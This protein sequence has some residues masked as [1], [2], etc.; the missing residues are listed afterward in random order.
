[1][2][3]VQLRRPKKGKSLSPSPSVFVSASSELGKRAAWGPARAAQRL[4]AGSGPWCLALRS[5]GLVT[6][7]IFRLGVAA[8]ARSR[9]RLRGAGS[10]DRFLGWDEAAYGMMRFASDAGERAVR[11]R[12]TGSWGLPGWSGRSVCLSEANGPIVC[13]SL[14][15]SLPH[16][17]QQ[18]CARPSTHTPTHIPDVVSP[19]VLASLFARGPLKRR[20]E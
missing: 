20:V 9:G 10:F 14:S 17:T 8:P 18:R 19:A 4:A 5:S 6:V 1:M 12:P 7:S 2:E 13:V 11:L 3:R 15:L 16:P